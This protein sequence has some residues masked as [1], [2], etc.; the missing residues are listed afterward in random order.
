MRQDFY[1]FMERQEALAT[2]AK[3]WEGTPFR[4]ACKVKGPFGG[5]DC[6]HLAAALHTCTG[7]IDSELV[8][9]PYDV[10]HGVHDSSSVILEWL[11][12]PEIRRRLRKVDE[13]ENPLTGDILLCEVGMAIHH[14]VTRVGVMGWHVSRRR[15]VYQELIG[16][17]F[18]Q[19]R[20]RAVYRIVEGGAS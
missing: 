1:R 20:V 4:Q 8:F 12:Q 16:A 5:V 15:G 6:A 14:M 11:D 17:K 10:D 19:L 2:E 13:D 18:S 3:S 9:P 7:A